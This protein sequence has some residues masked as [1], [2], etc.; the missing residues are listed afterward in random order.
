MH[1]SAR[2]N[3]VSNAQ[4]VAENGAGEHHLSAVAMWSLASA[5]TGC[6]H[7]CVYSM[8]RPQVWSQVRWVQLSQFTIRLGGSRTDLEETGVGGA[9]FTQ[10]CSRHA[11]ASLGAMCTELVRPLPPIHIIAFCIFE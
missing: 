10:C 2:K 7:L 1:F 3:P 8:F 9:H 11:P 4:L 6:S 5:V